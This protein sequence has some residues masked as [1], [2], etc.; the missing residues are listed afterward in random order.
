MLADFY[1]LLSQI[2]LII[3]HC[4][5]E[6]SWT[7]CWGLHFKWWAFYLLNLI[8]FDY[9]LFKAFFMFYDFLLLLFNMWEDTLF[10]NCWYFCSWFTSVFSWS[11][12]FRPLFG[13][14]GSNSLSTSCFWWFTLNFFLDFFNFYLVIIILVKI[15]AKFILLWTQ[16]F[17]SSNFSWW[18]L[19]VML[20][21]C[22]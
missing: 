22:D 21:L 19:L 8:V 7:H 17:L 15:L 3:P 12:L 5:V 10:D 18:L 1:W 2:K 16:F 20:L 14:A 13:L 11:S 9:I 4:V 6:L